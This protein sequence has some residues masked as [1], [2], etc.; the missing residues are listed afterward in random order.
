MS[1]AF[2]NETSAFLLGSFETVINELIKHFDLPLE[3]VSEVIAKASGGTAKPTLKRALKKS[4]KKEPVEEKKEEEKKPSSVSV[5]P[6]SVVKMTKPEL[7]GVCKSRGL[8]V[9]GAR[10]DLIDRILEDLKKGDAPVEKDAPKKQT[11]LTKAGVLK[12]ETNTSVL[13]KI[14]TAA[15]TLQIKRNKFGNYEHAETGLV[16]DKEDK[17]VI[18]KQGDDGNIYE[19]DDDDIENCK[20]FKFNYNIPENLDSRK[21]GLDD[22]KVDEVEEELGEEDFEEEVEEEV[23]EEEVDDE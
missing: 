4:P 6:E 7:S 5:T 18:G 8:K 20:R 10:Q 14:A 2:S 9:S 11:T 19:L 1:F 12:K 17:T 23:S 21:T 15:P 13:K 16:F 22:V 3:E